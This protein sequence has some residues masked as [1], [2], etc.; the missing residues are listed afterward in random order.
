[1]AA[2]YPPIIPS[3]AAGL[4]AS[5]AV[6]RPRYAR[7]VMMSSTAETLPSEEICR[8]AHVLCADEAAAE[9]ALVRIKNGDEFGNVAAETSSCPSKEKGG[10][11]GWFKKG[12][13]VPE[14]EGACFGN[15]PGTIV[16]VQTQF[17]WHIVSTRSFLRVI[18]CSWYSSCPRCCFA[19]PACRA[20]A[21]AAAGDACRYKP[22]FKSH[23]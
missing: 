11:L 8:A 18:L 4:I 17:G 20:S 3:L 13:M 16:K 2:R 1:M 9:A 6:R 7:A 14:F 22:D 12:Q 15:E 21:S 10:D 5:S 19:S 23:G